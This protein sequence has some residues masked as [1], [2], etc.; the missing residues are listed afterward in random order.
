MSSSPG[1]LPHNGPLFTLILVTLAS[2]GLRTYHLPP[3]P[4]L[5]PLLL[6]HWKC[7]APHSRHACILTHTPNTS[8]YLNTRC[9]GKPNSVVLQILVPMPPPPGR[10]P[11]P[12]SLP[13]YSE[14]M[15]SIQS[16][17][18]NSY[19]SPPLDCKLFE[20]RD[21]VSLMVCVARQGASNSGG[22]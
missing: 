8:K 18:Y 9:L 4:G 14:C 10:G 2:L 3:V 11:T 5:E 13:C 7:P 1:L 16:C 17:D 22:C 6:P 20:G 21:Q 19:L 15:M 12:G